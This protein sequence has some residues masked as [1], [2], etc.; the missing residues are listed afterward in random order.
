[1][2][3]ILSCIVLFLQ[4]F[5]FHRVCTPSLHSPLQYSPITLVI[6]LAP[7]NSTPSLLLLSYSFFPLLPSLSILSAL[8]QTP[9]P[10]FSPCAL[11]KS[12]E[13]SYIPMLQQL[14]GALKK[15]IL[16]DKCFLDFPLSPVKLQTRKN[17]TQKI[18]MMLLYLKHTA[19]GAYVQA[20]VFWGKTITLSL[21]WVKK[22]CP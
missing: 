7:S 8:H 18:L 3:S 14:F 12:R 17:K 20:T 19:I 21:T 13:Q 5:F 2:F 9:S 10:C 15:S 1:M 4:L 16:D 22:K 11:V 6:Y